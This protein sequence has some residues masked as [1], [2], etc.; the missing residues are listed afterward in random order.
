MEI[1]NVALDR[2]QK[3]GL[4]NF[5]EES[6][7]VWLPGDFEDDEPD[8]RI[9][10]D[11][12]DRM[13]I[14]AGA[15]TYDHLNPNNAVLPELS[16]F[17][18]L[19]LR[20]GAGREGRFATLS[21]NDHSEYRVLEAAAWVVQDPTRIIPIII[22]EEAATH[23]VNIALKRVVTFEQT[24]IHLGTMIEDLVSAEVLPVQELPNAD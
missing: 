13:A 17:A 18:R 20:M 21:A 19:E 16:V 11:A 14:L 24:L 8:F 5:W 7:K 15:I 3:A 2:Y 9:E 22:T 23:S 12:P 10:L 4:H 6:N 1:K